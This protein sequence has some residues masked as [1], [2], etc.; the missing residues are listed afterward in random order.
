MDQGD[1]ER[2]SLCGLSRLLDECQVLTHVKAYDLLRPITE[3][4][5]TLTPETICAVHARL[6]DNARFDKTYIP[7]GH[8]RSITRKT[9]F[10]DSG[11]GFD[12]IQCCPHFAVDG[13]LL[14]ICKT[15]QASCLSL[16]LDEMRTC[17]DLIAQFW[18]EKWEN[19]FAIASWLHL[20][21]A[22]CHPFNVCRRL[23][24]LGSIQQICMPY[25]TATGALVD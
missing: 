19:P 1:S 11:N 13:E 18:L 9:V 5:T 7:P 2:Y 21:L 22:R 24:C 25:R 6:M 4:I 20:V 23:L 15:V 16:Q 14:I 10:I 3:D 17:V 12:G 8:T